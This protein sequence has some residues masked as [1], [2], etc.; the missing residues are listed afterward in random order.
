M[1]R[2]FEEK[3]LD[4]IMELWLFTNLSA[5]EFVKSEYW[6]NNFDAVKTMM[7]EA[8]I[9]V[10]EENKEI[11]G[12]IGVMDHYIAG[13]FVSEQYQSKG[14]GKKLLD[15]VKDKNNKLS[16]SV[17]EKNE[18]AIHFYLREQFVFLKKQIDADTGE[19]EW[20]MNWRRRKL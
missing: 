15:Y 2:T 3:D 13:I 8:E 16:L 1:I 14:I 12:F 9:Y 19:M 5:H 6:K 18:R 10:Y 17:Y 11:Q 20:E 7:P 4:R